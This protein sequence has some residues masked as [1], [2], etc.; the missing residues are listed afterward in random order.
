[1]A[2]SVINWT[3]FKVGQ[4]RQALSDQIQHR[5]I[6]LYNNKGEEKSRR[7]RWSLHVS[8]KDFLRFSILKEWGDG[9][10]LSLRRNECSV[11]AA[12]T[13]VHGTLCSASSLLLPWEQ[14]F[15]SGHEDCRHN[16]S[17][18]WDDHLSLFG[19]SYMS[20]LIY[21]FHYL[22]MQSSDMHDRVYAISNLKLLFVVLYASLI[23]NF[24][25]HSVIMKIV[26]NV[27]IIIQVGLFLFT[28]VA[29]STVKSLEWDWSSYSDTCHSLAP[30]LHVVW[31][32]HPQIIT[33]TNCWCGFGVEM[34]GTKMLSY[35]VV[36]P[37]FL[38]GVR[39]QIGSW[40]LGVN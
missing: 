2:Q 4:A 27:S 34:Y 15:L 19:T 18:S 32:P 31:F 12:L 10:T 21:G 40:I 3:Y 14:V 33:R 22:L 1:M 5:F 35:S 7:R 37:G 23:L 36:D 38:F 16:N 24:L 6:R 28:L 29:M 8:M 11:R 9:S 25:N 17:R 30:T 26:L 39:T 13:H 20:G